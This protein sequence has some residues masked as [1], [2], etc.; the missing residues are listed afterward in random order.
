ME[1]THAQETERLLTPYVNAR[2]QLA[3]EVLSNLLQNHH[4]AAA[5]LMIEYQLACFHYDA[6]RDVCGWFDDADPIEP[7]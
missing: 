5:A 3:H 1:E 2:N 6:A 7:D 4:A